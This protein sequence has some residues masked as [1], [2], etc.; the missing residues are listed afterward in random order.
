MCNRPPWHS[1]FFL[2]LSIS[3]SFK[4]FLSSPIPS[5][6]RP[7][8][9]PFNRISRSPSD[10]SVLFPLPFFLPLAIIVSLIMVG[11]WIEATFCSFTRARA[12]MPKWNRR[13]F[14]PDRYSRDSFYSNDGICRVL[15]Y[16]M[17]LASDCS[18]LLPFLSYYSWCLSNHGT[19]LFSLSFSC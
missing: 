13:R 1:C 2:S 4:F 19:F 14:A 5:P 12:H 16:H 3:P 6:L 17:S 18:L 11:I 8:N 15:R 10:L 9:P 7:A